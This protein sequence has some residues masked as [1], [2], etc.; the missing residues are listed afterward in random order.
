MFDVGVPL[1]QLMRFHSEVVVKMH[2][3]SVLST[4]LSV[5]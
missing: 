4:L 3:V 5:D 1:Y 2:V